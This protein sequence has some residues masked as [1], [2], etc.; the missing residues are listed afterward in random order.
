MNEY[1]REIREYRAQE[2]L[3]K[4]YGKIFVKVLGITRLNVPIPRLPTWFTCTLNNGIHFVTTP[5]CRL[6]GESPIEQ[7]FELIEHSK[8]EFTLTMKVRRDAHLQVKVPQV[9]TPPPP[10]LP[11]AQVPSKSSMSGM[12]A[13]FGGSPKKNKTAPPK[14]PSPPPQPKPLPPR[15]VEEGLIRHIRPDGTLGRAFVAFKDVA[16]ECDTRLFE[17][18]F[19]LVGYT[20]DDKATVATSRTGSSSRV[21]GEVVLQLFRLPPLPGISPEKLPQSLDE[22]MRGLRHTSWHK[23]T[24]LESVLTQNGGDCSSWRRR[25]FRLVGAKMIAF[26]DVTKKATATIDLRQMTAVEDDN[27]PLPPEASHATVSRRRARD[28][29]DGLLKIERSFRLIFPE[30]EIEFYT[31]TDEEKSKWLQVLRT[32]KGRIPPNPLW[33]EL[34]WQQQEDFRSSRHEP[35]S[36]NRSR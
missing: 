34:V 21:I 36:L 14:T 12:R 28:S 7:E 30:E 22:C 17:T 15:V 6:M 13:F 4:A 25:Q 8:L 35:D 29:Y 1:A 3:G 24:Y 11:P 26:N 16:S 27:E 2:K 32:L 10:P 23:I 5:E 20:P 18:A 31:D 33:A 19:P 9:E